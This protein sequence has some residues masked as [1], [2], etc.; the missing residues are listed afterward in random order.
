MTFW[1]IL[2]N[3]TLQH[4]HI[5]H[6]SWPIHRRKYENIKTPTSTCQLWFF[7]SCE[8]FKHKYMSH[9]PI[10]LLLSSSPCRRGT[11]ARKFSREIKS[12]QRRT[13]NNNK[14][15]LRCSC[16]ML[17][18]KTKE[19][20]IFFSPSSMKYVFRVECQEK[21]VFMINWKLWEE[22]KI[23]KARINRPESSLRDFSIVWK[24]VLLP[25]YGGIEVD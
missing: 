23:I 22:K 12:Y 24:C 2:V 11:R 4:D 19:K 17:K 7:Q 16:E 1:A 8:W 13:H 6:L 25:S 10:P 3:W 5:F 18:A 9:H 15:R 14:Q 20:Y 21:Y